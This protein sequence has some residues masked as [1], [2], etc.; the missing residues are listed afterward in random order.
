MKLLKLHAKIFNVD[1]RNSIKKVRDRV[2][3]D[4]YY[5][6]DCKKTIKELNW[7]P[8]ISFKNGLKKVIAH[9]K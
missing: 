6:L 7:S 8:K 3:K 2:G 9:K 4:K 5:F 1:F